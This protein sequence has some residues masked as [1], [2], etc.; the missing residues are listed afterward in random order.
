MGMN[1]MMMG[2]FGFLMM[3]LWLAFFAL[4]IVGGIYLVRWLINESASHGTPLHKR[5]DGALDIARER[6]ARGEIDA[7]EYQWVK[8]V[9]EEA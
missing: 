6:L 7:E 3:T 1:E 9:L 2:G 8:K 4:L 5:R